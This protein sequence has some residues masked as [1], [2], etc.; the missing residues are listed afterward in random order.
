ML[1]LP[2]DGSIL[3]HDDMM[4][5][6]KIYEMYKYNYDNLLE[7]EIITKKQ[8]IKESY[9]F[10]LVMFDYDNLGRYDVILKQDETEYK[11]IN[12]DEEMK[13]KI[14]DTYKIS[15]SKDGRYTKEYAFWRY[16]VFE[17]DNFTCQHCNQKGG[18]LNAHHIKSY[19]DYPLLRT[20]L[21][22]GIT[23]CIDCHR[24]EHKRIRSEK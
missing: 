19:K 3:N 10:C 16:E 5:L 14:I 4:R 24:K 1:G 11:V 17:R 2:Y 7:D 20:K 12:L 21:D 22:N 18:K 15:R 13:Y 8:W 23:L 6:I 9:Y